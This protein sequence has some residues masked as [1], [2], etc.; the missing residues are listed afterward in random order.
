MLA[1]APACD[2]IAILHLKT[3]PDLCEE[4][5]AFDANDSKAF[6]AIKVVK[7][8]SRRVQFLTD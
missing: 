8:A 2:Q 4:I 6:V 5:A 1:V 7:V 3:L